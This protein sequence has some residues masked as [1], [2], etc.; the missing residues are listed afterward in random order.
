MNLRS[1]ALALGGEIS[2]RQV[3]APGPGHSRQDRSLSIRLDAS[4]PDGFLVHSFA[5]DPWQE[6]RDHVRQKLGLPAWE[7]GDEQNRTIPNKHVDKW[8]FAAV[9]AEMLDMTRSDDDLVRIRSA[10][11]IWNAA[12]ESP[13]QRAIDSLASRSLDPPQDLFGPQL[14]YHGQCP[15]RDENTGQILRV[16]CLIAAFRSIADD[17]ITGIHRIRVDQPERWPKTSRMM[18]GVIKHS[19]IKLG[20]AGARLAIGEGLETCLAAMQ[21]G[22]DPAWALGSVGNISFFPVI[23][24]VQEIRILCETGEA[25]RRAF[26]M[27]GRRWWRASRK[28]NKITPTVGSDLN[29]ALMSMGA[30]Q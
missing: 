14:R 21:A 5:G 4:A 23:D 15:F 25:S 20:A 26:K 12:S 10:L 11:E 30:A 19:A 28:V 2:G 8:D 18:L 1:V 9:E 29:D 7:P 16:P 17:T 6:C 22:I 13:D 27:C 3:I 24:G